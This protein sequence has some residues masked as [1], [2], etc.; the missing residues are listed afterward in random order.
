[1]KRIILLAVFVFTS[2][3]G[4]QAQPVDYDRPFVAVGGGGLTVPTADFGDVLKTGLHIYVGGG[5][6]V[7][8]IFA[9]VAKIEYS[10]NE[11]DREMVPTINEGADYLALMFGVDFI[12]SPPNPMN[13]EPFG[14]VGGGFSSVTLERVET[15][16][17]QAPEVQDT[18][19]YF[20]VGV[21]IAFRQFG[22]MS[23]FVAVRWVRQEMP[24]QAVVNS[25][26][27]AYQ[28]IPITVGIRF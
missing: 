11:Y 25:D 8:D 28:S 17:R 26:G 19:L 3:I 5:V 27:R 7:S 13:F 21:G 23:A 1:M 6:P 2:S 16:D 24:A 14:I 10:E 4:I 22:P 15:N 20:N 18:R 9:A 12:L